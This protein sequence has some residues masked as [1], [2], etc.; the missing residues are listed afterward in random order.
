MYCCGMVPR[1]IGT[2]LEGSIGHGA[3]A[4]PVA[5]PRKRD[6]DL[7]GQFIPTITR[8]LVDAFSQTAIIRRILCIDMSTIV[9]ERTKMTKLRNAANGMR[10]QDPAI[11]SPAF[12]R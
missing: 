3:V 2:C 11:E 8:L 1:L 6:R 9:V 10:T 5:G 4:F 12:Y 7:A